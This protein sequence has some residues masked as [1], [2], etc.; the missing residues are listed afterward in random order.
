MQINAAGLSLIKQF[1]GFSKTPYRCPAGIWT[2]GY[3]H[4]GGVHEYTTAIT[5]EEAEAL[6]ARDVR[7]AE[8]EVSTLVTVPLH[9]NQFSALT[10]FLFNVGRA[11]VAASTL[12]VRVNAGEMQLAA[13]EFLRWIYAS[14]VPLTGLKNRRMAE[15]QLFLSP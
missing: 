14:G 1:E 4:T 13:N 5:K 7:A 11:N 2:I 6:L 15:R 9:E 8:T 12:L 10:S 3:G